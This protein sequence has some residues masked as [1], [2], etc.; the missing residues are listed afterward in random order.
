M[1]YIVATNEE[2]PAIKEYIPITQEMTEDMPNIILDMA[3]VA[4]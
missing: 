1:H 4:E 2:N 3:N